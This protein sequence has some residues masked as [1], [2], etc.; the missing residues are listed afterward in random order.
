MKNMKPKSI[1]RF[2]PM[3][4]TNADLDE[5]IFPVLVQPKYDGVR[6]IIHPTLGPVT[7]TLKPIPNKFIRETLS[8]IPALKGMDGEILTY[9]PFTGATDDLN[10][11]VG[12]VM[13][14]DGEPEFVLHLFDCFTDPS[15]SYMARRNC[16]PIIT[17]KFLD[18]A[19]W[20]LVG[21]LNELRNYEERLINEGWEGVIIRDLS[22]PYKF[23]RSTAKEGA[24][25][26]LKRFYDDEARIIDFT[27]LCHNDNELTKDE[28]GLAKRSM[29][30]A[31]KRPA[32]KL[33]ALVVRRHL[34]SPPF[35]I[36]TGFTDEQ[37]V[38]LWNR[39][40]ELRGT[41]VSFKYQRDGPNG[42]PLLPVFKAFRD[43]S[44]FG[45]II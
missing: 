38:S 14:R 42:V 8:D 35:E 28:F 11:V 29:H 31:N 16:I 18:I 5:L 17:Q 2:R 10:Q 32:G 12:N 15:L 37:R 4:A 43:V 33:G 45:D 41:Y 39:R 23:G 19:P 34:D 6:C 13:S 26:K 27:E 44:D 25:L 1:D 20:G 22:A 30:K 21:D 3:L 7:R 36:G 9:D 24:L 40:S